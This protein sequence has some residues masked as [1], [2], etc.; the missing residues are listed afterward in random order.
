M[1]SNFWCI[2]LLHKHV[3]TYGI[4]SYVIMWCINKGVFMIYERPDVM[5]RSV[6][7]VNNV[8][9]YSHVWNVSCWTC[10]LKQTINQS[11]HACNLSSGPVWVPR[12][13]TDTPGRPL[14]QIHKHLTYT[15]NP[16]CH[17]S[18]APWWM[19]EFCG[20]YCNAVGSIIIL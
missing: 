3:Q 6:W 20:L 14:V 2:S 1:W 7:K 8:R 16:A 4:S 11:W 5:G 9:F 12:V 10:M 19:A 13:W 17:Y 15:R 18:P